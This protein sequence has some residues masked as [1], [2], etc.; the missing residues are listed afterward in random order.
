MP[1]TENS[2][3]LIA[4]RKSYY[5]KVKP[6]NLPLLNRINNTTEN[7]DVINDF[8][9][10]YKFYDIN[11]KYSLKTDKGDRFYISTLYG[12]DEFSY[13]FDRINNNLVI[14]KNTTESNT[15]S[16]TSVYY[17]K[18]FKNGLNT[19]FLFAYSELN[20]IYFDSV[21]V[22]VKKYNLSQFKQLNFSNNNTKEYKFSIKNSI[23]INEKNSLQTGAEY[24][25]NRSAITKDTFG[26]T[27]SDYSDKGNHVGIFI[28]DVLSINKTR[29][30]FGSRLSY[31]PYLNKF[32]YEP[33]VLLSSDATKFVRFNLAWGKYKQFVTKSSVLD[34]YG[35]YNYIWTVADNETI[36]VL[37]ASHFVCGM[38]IHKGGFNMNIEAFYK[39]TKGLTRYLN[40]I[41]EE[42]E[43]VYEGQSKSIGADVFIKQNFKGHSVWASYT[44]GKTEE[45]FTYQIY[46]LYHPAPQNQ[47]HELKLAGMLDLEPFYIS[48]DFV[49]G[50]GFS[51]RTGNILY[52]VFETGSYS[53]WDASIVFKFSLRR[54]SGEMGISVLNILNKENIKFSNFERIPADQSSVI[55]IY[56][57]PVPFTPTIS[58]TLGFK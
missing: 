32:Y 8:T 40:K 47:T 16:G 44:I 10:N 52:P 54:I 22:S 57:D 35:N 3:L 11:V 17:G 13:A 33:R 15:Q 51:I 55:N 53:R 46:K 14:S 27:Y 9:P 19:S 49:Y 37:Q 56:N 21:Q 26:I 39:K 24:I 2:S 23:P 42:K 18:I 43:A 58:L 1:I 31:L 30:I 5:Q 28:Q 20:S 36:P 6:E 7:A 48:S 34:D 4:G 25:E 45:M 38:N 50:S 41:N 29:L 12:S